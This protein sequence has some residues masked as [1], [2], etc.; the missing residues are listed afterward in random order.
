MHLSFLRSRVHRFENA[1]VPLQ[2]RIWEQQM[3]RKRSATQAEL[4]RFPLSSS[5][6]WNRKLFSS[7]P[8]NH[9][10]SRD[11][12]SKSVDL[13][14]FSLPKSF[15]SAF[16]IVKRREKVEENVKIFHSADVLLGA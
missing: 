9:R 1:K 14:I 6:S 3:D 16:R 8:S 5:G 4:D 10:V 13:E 2:N 12:T 15:T 11:F 7:L